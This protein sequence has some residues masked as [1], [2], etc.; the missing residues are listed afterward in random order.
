MKQDT[1]H[2]LIKRSKYGLTIPLT[3]HLTITNEKTGRS[4]HYPRPYDAPGSYLLVFFVSLLPVGAILGM[5]WFDSGVNPGLLGMASFLYGLFFLFIWITVGLG[6]LDNVTSMHFV[7]DMLYLKKR[8]YGVLVRKEQYRLHDIRNVRAGAV[9]SV[10]QWDYGKETIRWETDLNETE[11]SCVSRYL[12]EILSFNCHSVTCIIFGDSRASKNGSE[13][14]LVNPDVSELIV[15][16]WHLQ[17]VLIYSESY[18]LHQVEQFLTY[19]VNSLGRSYLK[20]HV[21][22]T[23]CGAPEKLHPNVYNSLTY[24]CKRVVVSGEKERQNMPP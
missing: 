18:A 9:H 15:P 5:F 24:L 13:T 6:L 21:I 12:S 19:A 8:L 4:L 2:M 23:I 20:H 7:R 22:V 11:M 14:L 3:K 16:C 10:L 17:Q 1:P